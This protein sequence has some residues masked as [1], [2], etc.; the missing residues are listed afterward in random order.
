MSEAYK[1]L[2]VRPGMSPDFPDSEVSRHLYAQDELYPQWTMKDLHDS[3]LAINRS[4]YMWK[5]QTKY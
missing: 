5:Y 2:D 3:E 4:S 1:K